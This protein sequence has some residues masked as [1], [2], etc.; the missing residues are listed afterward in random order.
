VESLRT[1]VEITDHEFDLFRRLLEDEVGI[2]LKEKEKLLVANRLRQV[3]HEL[4]LSNYFDYY[5]RITTGENRVADLA[6]L[7]DALTTRKTDFFRHLDQMDQFRRD[8]VPELVAKLRS[9]ECLSINIWS[10]GC[11]TGEEPYSLAVILLEAVPFPLLSSFSIL[12]TDVSPTAIRQAGAGVFPA[13]KI[14]EVSPEILAK[15]FERIEDGSLRIR[16]V[17]RRMVTFREHNLKSGF[18]PFG[19]FD[20]IF[21]RNVLIYFASA[22]QQ[23]VVSR[24]HGHLRPGGYLFVGHSETLQDFPNPFEFV[25]PTVYRRQP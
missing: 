8:V 7:I 20:V 21:C 22:F 17:V 15:Y 11:S 18:W 1:R 3:L 9:K 24:F 12:A 25:A 13:R 16:P 14:E 4:K 6:D 2:V 19:Q 5:R 23:E 10:A